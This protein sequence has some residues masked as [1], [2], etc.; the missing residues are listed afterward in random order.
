MLLKPATKLVPACCGLST[1][2]LPTF[3]RPPIKIEQCFIA[4]KQWRWWQTAG[5]DFVMDVKKLWRLIDPSLPPPKTV[6]QMD[7][8]LIGCHANPANNRF[9]DQL[10][11]D[12]DRM[13]QAHS[14]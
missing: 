12:D 9:D 5:R 7:H 6:L 14:V 11:R 1:P 13:I 4:I 10:P 8:Q 3:Y 2:V